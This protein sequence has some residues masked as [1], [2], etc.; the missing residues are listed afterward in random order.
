MPITDYDIFFGPFLFF[1]FS[2]IKP[3]ISDILFVG[4]AATLT[5]ILILLPTILKN[6]T[7]IYLSLFGIILWVLLGMVASGI[8]R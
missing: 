6:N 3:D 2:I 8:P 5:S 7:S 4:T 1:K